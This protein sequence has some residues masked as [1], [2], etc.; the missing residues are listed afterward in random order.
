MHRKPSFF[1]V[2]QDDDLAMFR[3]QH[4]ASPSLLQREYPIRYSTSSQRLTKFGDDT[5]ESG[6][7]IGN[8]TNS[9]VWGESPNLPPPNRRAVLLNQKLD[10]L[11]PLT[12]VTFSSDIMSAVLLAMQ[13]PTRG[14][15][16][17]FGRPALKAWRAFVFPNPNKEDGD[18]SF[19]GIK[20][21]AAAGRCARQIEFLI[22]RHQSHLTEWIRH[23]DTT[24]PFVKDPTFLSGSKEIHRFPIILVLDNLRSAL[25]VG[26]LFRTAEACACQAIFTCGITP[27]PG[28]GGA[29][30]IRKSA[31]GSENLVPTRHFA[32]TIEAIEHLRGNQPKM[33]IMAMETTSRSQMYNQ[34]NFRK[35]YHRSDLNSNMPKDDRGLLEEC[36][37]V[38]LIL[39]NEV[40]GVDAELLHSNDS[41][42]MPMVDEIIQL[43]TFGQKNSLNV[44]VCAPV[45]V[46]EILRQWKVDPAQK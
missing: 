39:G 29:E 23:R 14:Y 26:S 10:S 30:K 16:S 12:N 37:G 1:S 15:D 8:D 19:D 4:F 28:G 40:T 24:T 6:S 42:K 33:R 11:R 22:K 46:Y 25:N 45:V 35:Y 41:S 18:Q 38:A 20:L 44:A 2:H 3:R 5:K 17:R 43:P 31:L 7:E 34:V 36:T 9:T 32:T 27:H 21:D 13:D